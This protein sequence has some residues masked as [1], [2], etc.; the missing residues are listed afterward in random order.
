[1]LSVNNKTLCS[2]CFTVQTAEGTVCAACGYDENHPY[3]TPG[4]LP[5]GTLLMGQYTT[6]MV[7]G[8]GGFGV[9]YLAFDLQ[10][11]QIVAIKEYFPSGFA[12]R[13]PGTE[14]ITGLTEAKMQLYQSGAK[15][16]Y[17]EA[18]VVSQFN[19]NPNIINV[20]RFFYENNTAYYVMEFMRGVDLKQYMRTK[21]GKLSYEETLDVLRQMISALSAV[22]SHKIMHRDISPDNIYKTDTGQMKLLD[23]GAAKQIL[24]EESGSLSVILKNGFAPVEQYSKKG[25]QGPWT[26]IYALGAT[27]YCALTGVDAPEDA[28]SRREKD[29]LKM[30]TKLG[31]RIPPAFEKILSKMMAVKL[32]DRYQ[33]VDEISNALNRMWGANTK[34]LF[35][36]GGAGAAAL[37]LIAAL[38]L[39]QGRGA[40]TSGLVVTSK[41]NTTVTAAKTSA[42]TSAHSE[43][44][45][46][47]PNT[48][49]TH[50][51]THA[52]TGTAVN[53]TS[54]GVTTANKAGAE[55]GGVWIAAGQTE[56][57]LNGMNIDDV[58]PLAKLTSLTYLDLYENQITDISPLSHL[59]NLRELYIYSNYITDIKPLG[60]LKNLTILDLAYNDISD[61]TPLKSLVR[62]TSLNIE[63]N[64]LNEGQVADLRAAL[65]N[66]EIVFNTDSSVTTTTQTD[67]PPAGNGGYIIPGSDTRVLQMSD[68]S[69]LSPM[70]LRLARNEIYARHGRKFTD[71]ALQDYFNQQPWYTPVIDADKFS[72]D[73]LSPVEKQNIKTISNAEKLAG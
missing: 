34:I 18:Q 46:N 19:G 1:M 48:T 37:I 44:A 28:L 63:Y 17:E 61:L 66:C 71:Q 15:R 12:Y 72:D 67:E 69:N 64:P 59:T 26:D 10:N 55:I 21:G 14:Q 50:T 53:T 45:A 38:V 57:Y 3:E 35:I 70:Q 9:T 65:P 24:G 58:S 47:T 22:H 36:G 33:N 11:E 31:I 27:L 39:S 5:A 30:P 52:N 73:M 56:A 54:T 60:S 8:R 7:L 23:F 6:G 43:T 32:E 41:T 42:N 4:A 49:V 51:N 25:R 62:L 29:N 13:T 16:F 68:L 2:Y 20:Y 40:H